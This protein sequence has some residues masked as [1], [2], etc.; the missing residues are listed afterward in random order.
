M[1]APSPAA[2][3]TGSFA[4]TGPS[5]PFSSVTAERGTVLF[6]D[7]VDAHRDRGRFEEFVLAR[8]RA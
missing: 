4:C 8:L 5:G 7:L 6:T 2:D 1:N 3:G